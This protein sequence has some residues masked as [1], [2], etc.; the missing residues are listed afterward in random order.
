MTSAR[1]AKGRPPRWLTGV[2]VVAALVF[3]F[4]HLGGSRPGKKRLSRA[5]PVFRL[6]E[7]APHATHP[8]SPRVL[9]IPAGRMIAV[10]LTD[11]LGGCGLVT[12]FPGLGPHGTTARV[13]VPIG[14]TRMVEL[15]APHPGSYPYHCASN[16]YFGVIKAR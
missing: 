16:M 11:N 6:I 5:L 3:F 10:R 2:L 12:V 14:A 4:W 15:Y 8:Y 1:K 7:G 9:T 13:D